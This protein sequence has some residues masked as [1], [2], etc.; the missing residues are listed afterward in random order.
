MKLQFFKISFNNKIKKLLNRRLIGMG[1]LE[2]SL[3]QPNNSDEYYP[4]KNDRSGRRRPN[5][6]TSGKSRGMKML[7]YCIKLCM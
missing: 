6:T 3:E 1:I 5:E 2:E 4:V 7:K